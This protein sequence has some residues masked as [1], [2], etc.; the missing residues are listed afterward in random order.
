MDEDILVSS[1]SKEELSEFL[2]A[3]EEDEEG[4]HKCK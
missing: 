4:D 1:L 3:L 2:E